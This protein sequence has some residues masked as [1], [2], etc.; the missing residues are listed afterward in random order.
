MIT[1]MT[2]SL[3]FYVDL[4]G[5]EMTNKW[6]DDGRLRWCWLQHGG[7][8]LMLQEYL[9]AHRPADKLGVGVSVCFMCEDAL[10]VYH[11]VRVKGVE[12]ERPFVGNHLW[13]TSLTDPDGYRV[14][15]ESPTDVPEET[16]YSEEDR[17]YQGRC[18]H[19]P[20][21]RLPSRHTLIALLLLSLTAC[22]VRLDATGTGT[23]L[24]H[25]L[26]LTGERRAGQEL[27]VTVSLT[28][29]YTVP[30]RVACF[31]ENSATLRSDLEEV[32]FEDRATMVGET[33]LP[34]RPD[35]RPD[36]EVPPIE[37][38][39]R[40]VPG[41]PGQYYLTCNTPHAPDNGM[42]TSFTVRP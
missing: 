32:P 37:I 14:D 5:F 31:L 33:I 30:V 19:Q 2:A 41:E 1:D 22:G 39:Y 12:I 8:A 15:F 18:Y 42:G 29:A 20:G 3:R 24:F 27:T 16:V 13:V 36:Q 40:F 6:I 17:P 10:A 23:E 28:P 26:D 4:L 35:L 38:S 9:A 21:L 25:D 34:A 7:A 11:R